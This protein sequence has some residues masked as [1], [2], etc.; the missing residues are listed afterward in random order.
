MSPFFL[1]TYGITEMTALV[2]SYPPST[3]KQKYKRK[4]GSVGLLHPGFELRVISCDEQQTPCR[5]GEMGEIRLRQARFT[6]G[7]F[8]N[9]EA[10]RKAVDDGWYCTGDYGY[11]D[12]DEYVFV[13]DRVKDL[14]Q[15]KD[16]IVS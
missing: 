8:E 11:F 16:A 14:I 2:T 7:Y 1:Q 6:K 3:D 15:H 13:V 12:E 10:T 4:F 9:D 5:P